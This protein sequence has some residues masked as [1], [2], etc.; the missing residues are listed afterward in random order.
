MVLI[1]EHS[2]FNVILFSE[3]SKQL[4]MGPETSKIPSLALEGLILYWRR[5]NEAIISLSPFTR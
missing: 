5:K 3:F 2:L 1:D 4:F